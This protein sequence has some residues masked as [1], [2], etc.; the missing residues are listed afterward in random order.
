MIDDDGA[1]LGVM[2][3]RKALELASSKGL[4]LVEVAAT[5]MPPV[6]KILDYGKFKYEQKKKEKQ[7]KKNQTIILLKEVKFRPRTDT[8]D[9]EYKVKNIVKFLEEGNKVKIS[10]RFRGREMAYQDQ[11]RK[12][13]QTIISCVGESGVVEQDAKMEGRDLTAVFAPPGKAAK[14]SKPKVKVDAPAPLP[15]EDK[16]EA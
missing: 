4:D 13:V 15:K 1:Q 5:S 3:T 2:E 7:A 14:S 9:I 6:C 11:G 12:L 10:V 16:A 8:H